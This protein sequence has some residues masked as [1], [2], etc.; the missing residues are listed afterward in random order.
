VV[1]SPATEI[2]S[3]QQEV[4][5]KQ[6][7][8]GVAKKCHP[9]PALPVGRLVSGSVSGSFSKPCRVNGFRLGGRNDKAALHF[10]LTAYFLLLASCTCHPELVSGS[11]SEPDSELNSE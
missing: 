6:V 8:R 2:G 3:N 7:L 5:S 1:I 9:E 10:P 4:R 11:T